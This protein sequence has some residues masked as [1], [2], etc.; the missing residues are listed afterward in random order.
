MM[1]IAIT[2]QSVLSKQY[3]KIHSFIYIFFDVHALFYVKMINNK[4][5]SMQLYQAHK[6]IN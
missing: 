5:A 1:F 6:V 4:Y 3:V 2:N